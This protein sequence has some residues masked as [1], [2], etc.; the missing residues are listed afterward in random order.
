VRRP[1]RQ[2]KLKDVGGIDW[3]R[4]RHGRRR[5]RRT[6]SRRRSPRAGL[7]VTRWSLHTARDEQ[8]RRDESVPR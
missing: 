5:R 8:N 3:R 7:A 2:R 6:R 4:L 1:G